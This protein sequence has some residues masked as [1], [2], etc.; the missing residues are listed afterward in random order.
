MENARQGLPAPSCS[1]HLVPKKGLNGG[2][3]AEVTA[4]PIHASAASR[5]P[6]RLTLLNPATVLRE[7]FELLE[8]YSPVWYTEENHQRAIAALRLEMR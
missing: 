8:D 1:L 4:N 3:A 5:G 2:A 7:L 6:A